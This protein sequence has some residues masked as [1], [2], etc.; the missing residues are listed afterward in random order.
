MGEAIVPK[1]I[2]SVK[3]PAEPVTVDTLPKAVIRMALPI[4]PK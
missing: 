3:L 2:A 4:T 1:F